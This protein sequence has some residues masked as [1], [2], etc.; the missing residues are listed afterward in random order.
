MITY[1][2][3]SARSAK[4][5]VARAD[6][7]T[8]ARTTARHRLMPRDLA[9]WCPLHCLVS[10]FDVAGQAR[11]AMAALRKEGFQDV[12][13]VLAPPQEIMALEEA[14]RTRSLLMRILASVRTPGSESLTVDE[15]VN[16]ARRGH[17]LLIVYA[18]REAQR[19]NATSIVAHHQAHTSHY[20]G[21]WTIRGIHHQY[22]AD[23]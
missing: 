10:A 23:S 7:M 3:H 6:G 20:F 18:P 17:Y 13:M 12:D 14:C 11:A 21:R 9:T 19:R 15:Y 1:N 2:Q 16:E 22:G 8:A 5:A 4:V